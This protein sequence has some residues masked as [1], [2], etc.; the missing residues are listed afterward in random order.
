MRV[1]NTKRS[2]TTYTSPEHHLTSFEFRADRQ[3]SQSFAGAVLAHPL[4]FGAIAG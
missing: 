4:H 2:T 1:T 3:R